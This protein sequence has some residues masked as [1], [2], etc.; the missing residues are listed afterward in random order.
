LWVSP[1]NVV[2]TATA[3]DIQAEGIAL[4]VAK[5]KD[6]KLVAG[7]VLAVA[8]TDALLGS[9]SLTGRCGIILVGTDVDTHA[10][11]ERYLAQFPDC[12]VMR[13]TVPLGDVIR[14]AAHRLGLQE[15]LSE[16]RTLVN[17]TGS[18]QRANMAH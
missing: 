15:L 8:D 7:R 10:P 12:V 11:A 18:S 4:A 16:L 1:V 14:I 3:P 5:R 13:V 9:R 17:Q 6:M 2:V